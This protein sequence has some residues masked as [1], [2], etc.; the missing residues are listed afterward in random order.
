MEAEN[1][2]V[3]G[4]QK[5]IEDL[6]S[7][8]KNATSYSYAPG[9]TFDGNLPTE[10]FYAPSIGTPAISDM[11]TIRQGIRTDEYLVLVNT[12]EKIVAATTGCSPSYTTAGTLSDRKISVSKI[13]AN[14]QWCKSDF[15]STAS[16]LSN[17]PSFVANGLDG[18]DV[19]A[20]VR[21]MWMKQMIDGI[22]KDIFRLMWLG[23]DT[24]G[25]ANWNIAEGLLVKLYDGNAS[26]CVK[27]VSNDLPNQHNSVLAAGQALSTL[28]GLHEGAQIELKMLPRQEK[29]FWVTGSM[30]ENLMTSYES[31]SAST[32]ST[33]EMFRNV[34]D[35]NYELYYRGIPI[36]PLYLL[37][38][39]LANDS[40]C[41]WYDNVRH[42][43]VYTP[44]AS[45][46]YSNLVFG[47]EKSSDL[48]R[49]DM[50]YD[51]R[52]LTTFA[53]FEGRYGVQ[54]INCNLT[55]FAD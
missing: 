46:Q 13:S 11:F 19:T 8:F 2:L 1:K 44:K 37:D 52:L 14:L 54:Y 31:T 22:R 21:Q 17:D 7:Q 51:Q 50:F 32:S 3:T 53:Q 27:R 20:K 5:Q 49:I 40:T 30:Y 42:F 10:L 28:R 36:Q 12:L 26:Y 29:T 39:Y 16:A 33:S 24:S 25:N 43:A 45:S 4:L 23:N 18:Y 6:K 55:A 41:P 48:D 34:V 47:T 15:I 9:Y 38:N 35:G